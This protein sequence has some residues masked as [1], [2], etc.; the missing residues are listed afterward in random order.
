MLSKAVFT[1][2]L[3][4]EL[5]WG[6]SRTPSGR[7]IAQIN[8]IKRDPTHCRAAIDNLLN[9]FAKY[10]IP[11]TWA[12]CGYL[13]LDY[14]GGNRYIPDENTIKSRGGWHNSET[15]NGNPLF[16]GKDIV[17]KILSS[18]V[19]H[20]IGY[21]TFSHVD[22][23]RCSREV[24]EA[25]VADGVRLAREF[26][27]SLKS[28]VF[29]WNRVGHLDI[30][31][32]YGF[33]I[34]RVQASGLGERY[35]TF[36]ARKIGGILGLIFTPLAKLNW[37]DG[38]WETGSSMD[39]WSRQYSFMLLPRAKLGVHRAVSQQ[40]LL[41]LFLHPYTLVLQPSLFGKLEKLLILVASKRDKGELEVMTMGEL[42]TRMN[43]TLSSS[44]GEH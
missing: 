44:S 39:F 28:F 6:L 37:R 10:N 2:S 13:F 3:D 1:M 19:E 23:S 17:D 36:L 41:H 24:A 7:A 9:L 15:I 29:P 21:H 33:L 30:L 11:A 18:Q 8:G 26:N 20:E 4:T 14:R 16:C 43:Q 31:K 42:A 5:L 35:R 25:E 32:K 22:F 38:I 34:Y 40:K 12:T 27:L